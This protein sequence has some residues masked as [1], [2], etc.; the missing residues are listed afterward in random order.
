[1]KFGKL[2][3]IDHVDFTLPPDPIRTKELLKNLSDSQSIELYFGCPAWSCK[4]W[5]GKIYPKGSKPK[6]FLQLYA[7]HFNT[8]ELNTTHYRIPDSTTIARWKSLVSETFKFCPKIPQQISHRNDFGASFQTVQQFYE[9]VAP[10]EENLGTTFMQLSP[11]FNPTKMSSL[12][13]F[14][15]SF[16]KELPLAIEFRHED[17]FNEGGLEVFELLASENIGTVITDVA[18]RRDVLHQ[19]LTTKIATIRFVGNELH[20]TDYSRIDAWAN[21]LKNWTSQGL[22]HIYFFLHE[23]ED[24]LCPELAVYFVRKMNEALELKL[25]APKLLPKIVQG[26]LF[27]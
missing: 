4:E 12:E 21:L 25:S 27:S 20:V 10:L 6:E 15:K 24:I 18:G 17:W 22:Q 7:Q 26:S 3:N 14:I 9:A 23:P 2:S 13:K 8:I 11:Y 19:Q 16:P 1:M 5:I